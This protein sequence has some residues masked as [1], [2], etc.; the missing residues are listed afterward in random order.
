[1]PESLQQ[2]AAIHQGFVHKTTHAEVLVTSVEAASE[3]TWSCRISIPRGHWACH[4]HAEEVPTVLWAEAIRQVGT[5][6]CHLGYGL[7]LTT[8]FTIQSLNF[9]R[10]ERPARF[11]SHGPYETTVLV[12]VG[13]KA[14]RKGHL[15]GLSLGY[16]FGDSQATGAAVC[17]C[18]TED[19]YRVVR[20]H[21]PALD[22]THKRFDTTRI[23]SQQT[24]LSQKS[25]LHGVLGW[26]TRDP[27]IFDHPT[28]H[29]PGML[30]T[31]AVLE[32]HALLSEGATVQTLTMVFHRF[33]EFTETVTVWAGHS[34][35]GGITVLFLVG[36]K[37]VVEGWTA[38]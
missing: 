30:F 26:D 33:T 2:A 36:Q 37:V 11:P 4:P 20:R 10:L 35:R 38:T 13:D 5:A 12:R 29:L 22:A 16:T 23:V 21:A 7:P 19:E 6:I 24:D 15:T 28:D 8:A 14:T 1:M 9:T 17:R 25:T 34:A 3:D 27:F 18:L 32:A 31:E